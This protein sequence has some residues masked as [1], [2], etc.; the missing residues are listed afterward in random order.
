MTGKQK[1]IE[2]ISEKAEGIETATQHSI[3]ITP[4][5]KAED[6]KSILFQD[7]NAQY[8][9]AAGQRL[10]EALKDFSKA[11]N[12]RQANTA[13]IHEIM[14]PTVENIITGAKE[15]NAVGQKHTKTIVDE[16]NKANPDNKVTEEELIADN[17]KFVNG[18]TTDKYRAVQGF[19]S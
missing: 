13:I 16:Y 19:L 8:R 6:G 5:L 1:N 11:K 2:V 14:H 3:E 15:G 9:V 18:E 4:E 10:I 7:A 17:D 12:K